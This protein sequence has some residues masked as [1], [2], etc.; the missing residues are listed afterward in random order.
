MG[1]LKASDM[2]ITTRGYSALTYGSNITGTKSVISQ[3]GQAAAL[4]WGPGQEYDVMTE[5]PVNTVVWV[6]DTSGDW[7]RVL[8][9]DGRIGYVHTTLLRTYNSKVTFPDNLYGYV[10][11]TG[12]S[13]I[14]RNGPS[15]SSKSLG[16]LSSGDV[17][18]IKADNTYFWYFF[19]PAKNSYAYISRDILSPEGINR[20]AVQTSLYYD[21][22]YLY[23]TDVLRTLQPGQVVKVLANDGYISRVQFD[24]VIG[25]VVNDTLV[26]HH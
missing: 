3:S 11:V 17:V 9:N 8:L 5:L 23:V 21:N 1:W 20:T 15:Y 22:P 24:T 26:I 13:A 10:Q 6:F 18:Q 2:S 7:T 16:T 19:N 25:Y 14:Y 12:N 4:R